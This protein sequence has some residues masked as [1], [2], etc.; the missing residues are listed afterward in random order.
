MD[1]FGRSYAKL[2]KSEKDK[3]C[4]IITYMWKLK[5]NKLVN[6]TKKEAESETER[7]N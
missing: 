4:M 5:T 1:G 7:S 2:N 6:K 3:Y